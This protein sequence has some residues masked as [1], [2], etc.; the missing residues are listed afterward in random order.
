MLGARLWHAFYPAAIA[1]EESFLHQVDAVCREVG[2][3][4]RYPP[5]DDALT[6]DDAVTVAVTEA[7]A[8]PLGPVAHET[9]R[10]MPRTSGTSLQEETVAEGVPPASHSAAAAAPGAAT[11]TPA[12]NSSLMASPSLQMMTASSSATTTASSPHDSRQL[13]APA[14]SVMPV[15]DG[16]VVEALL[17]QQKHAIARED[18]LRCELA[19]QMDALRAELAPREPQPAFTEAQIA[20]VQERLTSM[21]D[22]EVLS[23]AELW[24]L[25]DCIA[26]VAELRCSLLGGSNGMGPGAGVITREMLYM[27]TASGD[28]AE[29]Q[30]LAVATKLHKLIGVSEAV[31]MDTAFARQIKRKFIAQS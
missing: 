29:K 16:R 23:D 9:E 31:A 3:R 7:A 14:A 17:E 6:A 15:G 26:D 18:S 13:F 12:R 10:A 24:E 5:P 27:Y 11:V 8:A 25:E 30:G 4:C 20:A 28:V 19:A 22:A 21:H 1:N 2:D